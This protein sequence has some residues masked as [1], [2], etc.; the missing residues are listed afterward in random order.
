ME[1]RH[2]RSAYDI[3]SL[4]VKGPSVQLN[5]CASILAH[6][7]DARTLIS[8]ISDFVVIFITQEA[9]LPIVYIWIA[10]DFL[11][12]SIYRFRSKCLLRS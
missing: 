7:S 10:F 8:K 12:P 9:S 6:I 3:I 1:R 5:F 4:P 11:D 2:E